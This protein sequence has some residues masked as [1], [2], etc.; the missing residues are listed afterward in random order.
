MTL[1]YV[2]RHGVS[3]SVESN[4]SIRNMLTLRHAEGASWYNQKNPA[5]TVAGKAG[6]NYNQLE[7]L[8]RSDTWREEATVFIEDTEGLEH[9]EATLKKLGYMPGGRQSQPQKGNRSGGSN[10]AAGMSKARYE[11]L[12]E[13]VVA[14]LTNKG[15]DVPEEK[16]VTL[17]WSKRAVSMAISTFR[18]T[19][20]AVFPLLPEK[21]KTQTPAEMKAEI[22]RLKAQIAEL[23]AAK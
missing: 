17:D 21:P 14:E 1:T 23:N 12:G 2:D 6:L 5:M 20:D 4:L 11:E 19:E 15:A 18:G 3:A 13:F 10:G 9:S 22:E 8:R 7:S 16:M